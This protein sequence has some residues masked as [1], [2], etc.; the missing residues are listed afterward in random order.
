MWSGVITHIIPF[1]S[2]TGT[3]QIFSDCLGIPAQVVPQHRPG[4]LLGA[5]IYGAVAG[6]LFPDI[7]KAVDAMAKNPLQHDGDHKIACYRPNK[8]SA[9]FYNTLHDRYAQLAA[10]ELSQ[11]TE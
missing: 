3:Q 9:P 1:V 2:H 8:A 10:F 6:G 7:N 11:R 5:A 4:S